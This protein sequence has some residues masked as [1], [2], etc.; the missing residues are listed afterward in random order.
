MTCRKTCREPIEAKPKSKNSENH[1]L[2]ATGIKR[3]KCPI[4]TALKAPGFSIQDFGK[5]F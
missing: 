2:P 3:V 1:F 4:L 5:K